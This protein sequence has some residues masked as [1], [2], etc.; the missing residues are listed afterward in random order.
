MIG[1]NLSRYRIVRHLAQGGMGSVYLGDDL[2]LGRKVAIK[3]LPG[4]ALADDSTRRRFRREAHLLLR[5]AHPH[6]AQ[7][8]EFDSQD[9]MDFLVME[10]VDGESV[11]NRLRRGVIE[12]SEVMRLTGQV[13]DALEL[14]HDRGVIHRDL[15]PANVMLTR[16]G[17][18]KL[19]DFGLAALLH[20]VSSTSAARTVTEPGQII[21]TPAYLAPEII[22]GSHRDKRTD[23]YG[24]GMLMYEMATG[25]RPFP[26]D[27]M[28][29]LLFTIL[30]Q[31]PPEPRVINRRISEH[32]Q[33]V[34]LKALQ[35]DPT[36][37]QQSIGELRQDLAEKAASR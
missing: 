23:I 32:L 21:G 9:G 37:R 16:S 6:I 26:D 4:G 25:R 1:Q 7:T 24:V 28:N 19:L 13:L 8:Y 35:K 29:E 33:R 11:E 5:L 15:K 17:D 30:N 22:L 34:I 36:N 31:D 3:V 10:F 18:A 27:S 2:L 14:A 12:E 20:D